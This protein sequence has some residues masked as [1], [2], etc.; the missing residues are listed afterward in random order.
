MKNIKNFDHLV[1]ICKEIV[2]NHTTHSSVEEHVYTAFGWGS[3]DIMTDHFGGTYVSL[4]YDFKTGKVTNWY[5]MKDEQVIEDI[6]HLTSLIK[7]SEEALL[8][9][10]RLD[11]V[12]ERIN[13][14]Y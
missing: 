10:G 7:D 5:G 1:S 12:Y 14:E 2:E 9:S 11:S 6:D 8:A 4:H 13:E 3:V